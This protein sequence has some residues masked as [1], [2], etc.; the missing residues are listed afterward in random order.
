MGVKRI[1]GALGAEIQKLRMTNQTEAH[2]YTQR[3]RQRHAA[4]D[5]NQPG[6]LCMLCSSSQESGKNVVHILQKNLFLLNTLHFGIKIHLM[7]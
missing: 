5:L 7:T 2:R 4:I 1:R 3:T 6:V